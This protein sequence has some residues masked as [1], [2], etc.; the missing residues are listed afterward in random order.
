[1]GF[2]KVFGP[3][4]DNIQESRQIV[5]DLGIDNELGGVREAMVNV[6]ELSITD[7]APFTIQA[8]NQLLHSYG[9]SWVRNYP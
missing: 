1:V 5:G 3:V 2:N 7:Q 6:H 8:V 9:Y 4:V